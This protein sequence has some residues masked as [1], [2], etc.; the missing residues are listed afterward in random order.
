MSDD[1]TNDKWISTADAAEIMKVSQATVARLC[2]E[3]KIKCEQV[4]RNWLVSKK[5]ANDYVKRIGRPPISD[6]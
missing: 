4:A 1:S 5:A 2:R 6:D 3:G